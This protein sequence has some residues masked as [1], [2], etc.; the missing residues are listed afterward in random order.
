MFGIRWVPAIKSMAVL[1]TYQ[2][3]TPERKLHW[4][5]NWLSVSAHKGEGY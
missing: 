1:S 3:I 2:A 5:V 4:R